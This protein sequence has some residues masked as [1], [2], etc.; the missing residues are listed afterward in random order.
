MQT[1]EASRTRELF[2]EQKFTS[3]LPVCAWR[4]FKRVP[5]SPNIEHVE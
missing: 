4:R 3:V 5:L 1:Q 2:A